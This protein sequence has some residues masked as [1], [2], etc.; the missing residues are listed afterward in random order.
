MNE[1]L[2][3]TD[4]DMQKFFVVR[5]ENHSHT[6]YGLEIFQQI[7]ILYNL[8]VQLFFKICLIVIVIFFFLVLTWSNSVTKI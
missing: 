2:A 7:V 8:F 5:K 4:S 6:E 3:T 1:G